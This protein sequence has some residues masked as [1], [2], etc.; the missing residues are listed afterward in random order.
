MKFGSR[1][2]RLTLNIASKWLTVVTRFELYVIWALP[3][4]PELDRG[5]VGPTLSC[6]L[7]GLPR[8]ND[9][10]SLVRRMYSL[11]HDANAVS[12]VNNRR[13][14]RSKSESVSEGPPL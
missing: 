1:L 6:M 10:I 7:A 2:L 8:P 13:S 4:L 3:V 14:E 9:R 5:F 11:R 12:R